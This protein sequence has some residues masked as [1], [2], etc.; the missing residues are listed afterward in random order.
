MILVLCDED[1]ASAW[2]AAD[3]LRKR[4][5]SPT[6]LTG[7]DL[8]SVRG[9]RHTIG[10]AAADCVL[11]LA[12]GLRLEGRAVSGVLNRLSAV[13]RAWCDGIGGRDRDYAMY[14]MHAFYLSWLHALPCTKLNPPTPQGLCGNMRHP[15]AWRAL[16]ARAGLPVRPF[17]QNSSDDPAAFWRSIPDPSAQTIIVAGSQVIGSSDL[18]TVHRKACLRLATIVGAPLLGID[19][20]PSDGGQWQ[21]A[22][23]TVLPDLT[24]GGDV[25]ADAIAEALAEERA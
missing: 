14:E 6:V 4:G 3:A 2:W 19:F 22:G 16:A 15:S 9:W 7:E 5:V 11:R 25:L 21:V 24:C 12:D 1:D 23:A 8:A 13:P 20:A 18:A 10:A 17:Q